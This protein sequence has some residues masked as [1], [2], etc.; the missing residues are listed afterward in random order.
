MA[1]VSSRATRMEVSRETNKKT[2]SE[3]EPSIGQIQR[4]E[5]SNEQAEPILMH[6]HLEVETSA[7]VFQVLRKS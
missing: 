5:G 3:E 1:V 7:K 6:E 4:R 2:S